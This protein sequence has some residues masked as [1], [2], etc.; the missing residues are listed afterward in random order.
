MLKIEMLL[1]LNHAAIF[2]SSLCSV[3]RWKVVQHASLSSYHWKRSKLPIYMAL[4]IH[5]HTKDQKFND[6]LYL[7]ILGI[8]VI[9]KC[10]I[11]LETQIPISMLDLLE[12]VKLFAIIVH[13]REFSLLHLLIMFTTIHLCQLRRSF[14]W[15][16]HLHLRESDCIQPWLL[17]RHAYIQSSISR[18]KTHLSRSMY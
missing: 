17:Q 18:Q 2:F 5:A 8:S 3:V 7:Y 13:K 14:L 10:V 4:N 6:C 12:I 9:Y 16:H 11:G 15:N 1:T